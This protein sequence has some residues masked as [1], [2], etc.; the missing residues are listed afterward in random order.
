MQRS[1]CAHCCV[2]LKGFSSLRKPNWQGFQKRKTWSLW[3]YIVLRMLLLLLLLFIVYL[4]TLLRQ[5][6][7]CRWQAC[8]LCTIF[9]QSWFV[10]WSHLVAKQERHGW[11][12]WP[13]NHL[14]L[15]RKALKIH[16]LRPGLNPRTLGP[17]ASTLPLDHRGRLLR[18]FVEDNIC[19]VQEMET[20]GSI[21][22]SWVHE[23][24]RCKN[25]K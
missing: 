12:T 18:I 4:T 16:R 7:L 13:L 20:G 10:C 14:F 21:L 17:V 25:Q 9:T 11:E 8:C 1:S 23:Q 5:K 3:N 6:R 19:S 15:A 22:T 2:L 24:T